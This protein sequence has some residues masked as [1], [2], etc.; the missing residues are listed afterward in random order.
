[1]MGFMLLKERSKIVK[2]LE[3][4]LV[5]ERSLKLCR[6]LGLDP[7]VKSPDINGYARIVIA[8]DPDPDGAHITSL[9]INLFYKWFSAGYP[10]REAFPIENTSC[11]YRDRKESEILLDHG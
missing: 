3:I 5:T 10:N 9:I 6:F 7:M 2:I 1:M 11:D 4:F 8:T